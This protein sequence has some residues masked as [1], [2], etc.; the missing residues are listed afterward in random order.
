[1]RSFLLALLLCGCA[2]A[3]PVSPDY[4]AVTGMIKTNYT[5]LRSGAEV[6][7]ATPGAD[8][9]VV[10][11]LSGAVANGDEIIPTLT[12][13]SPPKTIQQGALDLQVLVASPLGQN[14]SVQTKTDVAAGVSLLTTVLQLAP[15]IA[16]LL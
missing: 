10:K 16:P 9:S 8:P 6:F 5:A 7:I 1:M 13:L 14:V 3:P 2:S 15:L 12:A 11:A 4:A